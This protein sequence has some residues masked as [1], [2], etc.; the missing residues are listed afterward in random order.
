MNV[1]TKK[2]SRNDAERKELKVLDELSK[3]EYSP[4]EEKRFQQLLNLK[5]DSL[6]DKKI[7]MGFERLQKIRNR[8]EEKAADILARLG[9]RHGI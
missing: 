7:V 6:Q 3:E 9:Q 4:R 5:T 1:L 8:V 2:K